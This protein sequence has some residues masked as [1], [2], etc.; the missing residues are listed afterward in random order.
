MLKDQ[1]QEAMTLH[2][3]GLLEQAE[4]IYR[5]LLRE[6]PR[7][8]GAWHLLGV[9]LHSRRDLS[10]ALEHIEKALSLCDFKAVYWN[11]YGAVLKDAGRHPEARIAFEK[12]ISIRDE[13]A[14]AWSN[15]GLM[16][17][18]LGLVEEAEKSI[19]YALRLEP[20]HGDALRHLAVV[21][22]EKGEYE[23]ALRLCKDAA[24]VGAGG[25]DVFGVEGGI[26]VAMKRYEKAVS[27]YDRA[28]SCDPDAADVHLNQGAAFT[29]LGDME[30]AR[31][32]YVRAA[33]LR[34]DRPMWQLRH[35]SLCPTIFDSEEEIIQYRVDLESQLDEALTDPPAFDWRSALQDGFFPSFQ[36]AHHG[37]CNQQIKEKFAR[38]FAHSFPQGQPK[39]RRKARIRVGFTCTRGHEGGFIR[40]FGGIIERLDRRRFDV[41]GLVS[42]DI[43]GFCRTQIRSDDVAW[44]GFPHHM[45]GA[46]SVFRRAEC[47]VVMHWQAGTDS[48]NFFLPFLPL[49]PVQC[50]GFGQHGTSGIANIDYFVSSR[51]FERNAEVTDD[52]TERPV[53]FDGATAWQARPVETPRANRREFGLPE[54]G[55]LYFC[56]QRHA[57]FH[58]NFDRILRGILKANPTGH[59]VILQGRRRKSAE[60]LRARLVVSL[61][62]TLSRRVL[63]VASQKSLGYYRLLSTMNVVL[64]S[65]AYSA[66]LTG[67]DA[68]HFGIPVVTLPG[69]QMVQR[70]AHGLYAQM[71]LGML[72][73]SGE[74][75]YIDLAARLGQEP[76]FRRQMSNAIRERSG[77]LFENGEVIREYETFF[78]E[79]SEAIR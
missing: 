16:Q 64:D 28:I 66:S 14:D 20:R 19:R 25:A 21:C 72:T 18:E 3:Q 12:A 79:I 62:K 59:V 78:N 67:Y 51:L 61:G 74:Q 70:Y 39:S 23:E 44:I 49:A 46:F 75:A 69:A 7:H 31:T 40:G 58:P 2:R 22:R 55:T 27:A 41:V 54:S 33:Q 63:F 38:L 13:Y 48:A 30:G 65:P 5:S 37:V 10:G 53:Q 9:V 47:D 57:K 26:L 60:A 29:D 71:G 15:L 35:L 17:T 1:L 6:A 50:I 36:L 68:F 73:V 34:P 8:A 45:Q 24:A 4:G 11:N 76:D 56:P 43:L 32:S 52:Y 77:I 42:Q